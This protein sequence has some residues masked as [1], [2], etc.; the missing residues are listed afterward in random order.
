MKLSVI[1]INY[2]VKHFLEQC[3]YSVQK[4]IAGIDAEVIVVDNNSADDS[5]GYLQPAFPRV[6]FISNKENIGFGRACNQ[7]FDV[8]KGNFILYLNPDT[9]IPEDCFSRCISFLESHAN[10]GALGVKMLDGS[11]KF[12]KESKR[13]FPSPATS[14]FKLLGLSR[15]FSRS[16]IFARYHLGHLDEEKNQEVEVL[17]GAFMMIKRTVLEKTGGFD[18]A[19]FMYGE[20][21][22]LSYRIQKAGYKNYYYAD[23]PIIHFKGE[24]SRKGSMNYVR[25]FYTAM[26]IFVRKHYPSGR[27]GLFNLLLQTG[28]WIRAALTAVAHFI[29]R[30][31]LPVIDAG[32]ILMSFWLMKNLWNNYIR[33]DVLY[34]SRLLWITFPIFTAVYLLVAYYAGLYDRPYYK[35]NPF[36]AT[37]VATLVLLAGYAMLPEHYRFSRAII[38]FGA[39][40]AFILISILHRA[41]TRIGVLQQIGYKE[42]HPGTLIVASHGEYEKAVSFIKMAGRKERILGRMSVDEKDTTGIGY[43]KKIKPILSTLPCSEIIYC[44]GAIM[45]KEIIENC[46]QLPAKVKIKFH[47]VGSRSIVG[48]DSKNTTGKILSAEN[49]YRLSDPYN[50]RLK[51]LIDISFSILGLLT[52]PVHIFGIKKPFNFF[53]NCFSVLFAKKTWIGYAITEKKLPALRKGVLTCNGV[54]LA[55]L[56]EIPEESLGAIDQ[57]YAADYDPVHDIKMLFGNYRILGS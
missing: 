26:S 33:T 2:N 37:L 45:F 47:A 30:I 49:G 4:A 10:A 22:D 43:Y 36:R 31:G 17:A 15:L 12:L 5:V 34:E 18:E 23:C 1:I 24:S 51:R 46:Q 38:L 7:G 35:S 42:E 52:F 27:A 41:L 3:L 21:V 39:L 44:E 25:M 56:K 55:S 8:A 40:L 9:I 28:I 32:L 48:S 6:C 57:W 16:K 29:R 11:G 20:D 19:F 13:A 50:R 54:A 53:R 14:L